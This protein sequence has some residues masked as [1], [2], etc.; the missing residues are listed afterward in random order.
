MSRQVVVHSLMITRLVAPLA[1]YPQMRGD[2][3]HSRN[4]AGNFA[5][6]RLANALMPSSSRITSSA[7]RG[8]SCANSRAIASGTSGETFSAKRNMSTSE[9]DRAFFYVLKAAN[10]DDAAFFF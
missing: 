4:G 2:N 3:C 5:S 6:C 9:S 7:S 1:G 10:G 8:T